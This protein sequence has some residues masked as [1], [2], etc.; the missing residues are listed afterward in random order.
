MAEEGVVLC[1]ARLPAQFLHHAHAVLAAFPVDHGVD[2]VRPVH[3]V[4]PQVAMRDLR[5]FGHDPPHFIDIKSV[6]LG[7]MMARNWPLFF[8]TTSFTTSA[9]GTEEPDRCRRC[10][11]WQATDL[12]HISYYNLFMTNNPSDE[13]KWIPVE[14][15]LPYNTN[16]YNI[17]TQKLT[18]GTYNLLVQATD[19]QTPAKTG[20]GVSKE[21]IISRVSGSGEKVPVCGKEKWVRQPLPRDRHS[22]ACMIKSATTDRKS[23]V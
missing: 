11:S 12:N 10:A 2:I 15:N 17:T 5:P 14:K 7:P 13:S 1:H 8:W 4:A 6:R 22:P 21:I 3:A 19:N 23:V 18:L 20:L 16:R 9:S